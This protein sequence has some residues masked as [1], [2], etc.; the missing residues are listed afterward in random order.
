MGAGTLAKQGGGSRRMRGRSRNKPM[1]EINVTPFVDVMLVLLII[2]MVAAPLLTVGVPVQLPETAA[3]TLEQESEE[4]LTITLQ[5]DGVIMVQ[6][7]AV[8]RERLL[9]LLRAVISERQDDKIFLRGDTTLPY[10]EIAVVM[11]A[12][13]AAGYRNIGLVTDGGGPTLDGA[14]PAN[15]DGQ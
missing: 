8:D 15:G 14:A 12:L 5:A 3:R 13:N 6:E 11:G 1:S 7:T 4:P 10:G 9:P 2:F